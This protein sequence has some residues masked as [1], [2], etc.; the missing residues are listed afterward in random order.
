MKYQR[1]G[2][3]MCPLD[4]QKFRQDTTDGELYNLEPRRSRKSHNHY[5]ACIK[6]AFDNLSEGQQAQFGSADNLRKFALI[7]EGYSHTQTYYA[8]APQEAARVATFLRHG[9]DYAIV[10]VTGSLVT[11]NTAES[12]SMKALGKKRFEASKDAVL[13][14]LAHMIGVD[15]DTLRANAGASA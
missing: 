8:D 3:T 9:R 13:S 5:F 12:Q 14:R 1:R 4:I 10:T 7:R 11:Y 15:A 2:D 6:T